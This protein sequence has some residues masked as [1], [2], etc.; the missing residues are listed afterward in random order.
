M[1]KNAES[2]SV[3]KSA[4]RVLAILELL[5]RVQRPMRITDVVETL[6]YPRA[7]AAA[8]LR[9]MTAMGYLTYDGRARVFQET[10]RA[11]LLGNWVHPDLIEQGDLL[12]LLEDLREETG[13]TLILA[14]RNGIYAHYIHVLNGNAPEAVPVRRGTMRPLTIS[15]TGHALIAWNPEDDVRR[16]VNRI[17]SEGVAEK[18]VKP[19]Q[20]LQTLEQICRRGYALTTNL[21]IPGRG[22]VAM[23]VPAAICEQPTVIG[24]V[25]NASRVAMHK[26]QYIDA[27]SQALRRLVRH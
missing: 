6:G 5:D 12:Q 3:V 25:A 8:L 23:P 14:T 13:E 16:L 1:A 9:S 11:A 24:L 18:I 10:P 27:L 4:G 19:S 7:S 21:V 15:T 26:D 17:N 20:L 22:M 2:F